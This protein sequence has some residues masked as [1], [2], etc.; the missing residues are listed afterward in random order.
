MNLMDV[1]E[2]KHL[3]KDPPSFKVGDRV[4]VHQKVEEE[5]RSRV[6]IFEGQVIAR[7]GSGVRANFCVRRIASGEGVERVFP[8]HSPAVVKV[9]VVKAGNYHRAKLY[10]TRQQGAKSR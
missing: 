2:E 5:G 7:K 1:V 9:Q 3:K 6:Q 8:L 10:Y 4:K